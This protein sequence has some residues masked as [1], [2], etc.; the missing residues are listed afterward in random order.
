MLLPCNICNFNVFSSLWSYRV[1]FCCCRKNLRTKNIFSWKH[2]F[3]YNFGSVKMSL[4]V[5]GE[6]NIS[7]Q[8]PNCH[9]NAKKLCKYDNIGF[10]CHKIMNFFLR[11][12]LYYLGVSPIQNAS[13]KMY[14]SFFTPMRSERT[15]L[16]INI[17]EN[18]KI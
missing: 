5:R 10:L 14:I 12:K 17:F 3:V 6:N 1:H 11:Y 15:S 8:N 2:M 9:L 18:N 16:L 7:K 4:A 13:R